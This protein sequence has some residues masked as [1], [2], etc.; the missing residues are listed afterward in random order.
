MGFFKDRSI[1]YSTFPITKQAEQGEWFR[2]QDELRAE[3]NGCRNE[4]LNEGV[5]P[6]HFNR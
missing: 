3:L 1:Y 4:Y 5:Y 2:V 6:P